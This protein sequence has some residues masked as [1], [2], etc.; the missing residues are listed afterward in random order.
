MMKDREMQLAQAVLLLKEA[1]LLE[2]ARFLA[3]A[4]AESSRPAGRGRRR[5]TVRV[6]VSR[7]RQWAVLPADVLPDDGSSGRA[8][9]R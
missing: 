1:G 5:R 9:P 6:W 8:G 4:W 2:A 3:K 7:A